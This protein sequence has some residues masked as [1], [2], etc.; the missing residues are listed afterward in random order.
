MGSDVHEKLMMSAMFECPIFSVHDKYIYIYIFE[1]LLRNCYILQ[2]AT[3][4]RQFL[5]CII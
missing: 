2:K 4:A 1:Y 5:N 3:L